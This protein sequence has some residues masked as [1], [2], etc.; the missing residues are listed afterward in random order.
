MKVV[1]TFECSDALMGLNITPTEF[2]GLQAQQMF[3]IKAVN[4]ELGKR[5]KIAEKYAEFSR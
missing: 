4:I 5:Y 1:V 2:L 3:D